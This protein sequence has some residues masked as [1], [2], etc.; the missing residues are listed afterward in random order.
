VSG[1]CPKGETCQTQ[2]FQKVTV[3]TLSFNGAGEATFL[4][5]T[6]YDRSGEPNSG[7]PVKGTVWPYTVSGFNGQLGTES[8]GAA[9]VLGAFNASGIASVVQFFIADTNPKTGVAT[10]Q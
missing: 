8:N 9:M 1:T 2:T 6:Q 7:G 3:G 10:L 4:T 5:V